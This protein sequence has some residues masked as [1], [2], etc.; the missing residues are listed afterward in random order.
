M[1][2]SLTLV[3]G[4]AP[5]GLLRKLLKMHENEIF[6]SQNISNILYPNPK[7]VENGFKAVTLLS[8]NWKVC[9]LESHSRFITDLPT[10]S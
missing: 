5:Q 6:I 7:R 10:V 3:G 4:Y 1:L 2:I 8:K 9:Y